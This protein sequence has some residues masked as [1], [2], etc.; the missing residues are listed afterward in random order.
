MAIG[1]KITNTYTIVGATFQEVDPVHWPTIA[2]NYYDVFSA[3]AGADTD[4][5]N[6]PPSQMFLDVIE[7]NSGPLIRVVMFSDA[8]LLS[9]NM[10]GAVGISRSAGSGEENSIQNTLSDFTDGLSNTVVL[11]S[12]T[13]EQWGD[14]AVFGP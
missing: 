13:V 8:A 14:D 12:A 11:Q 4:L 7:S 1:V 10:T 3:T 2:D 6:W 5:I 9:F